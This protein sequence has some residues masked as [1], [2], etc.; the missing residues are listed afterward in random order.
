MRIVRTPE[1]ANAIIA[2]PREGIQPQL[3]EFTSAYPQF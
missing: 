1:Y 3:E 2:S